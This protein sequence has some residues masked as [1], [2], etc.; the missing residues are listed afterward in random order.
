MSAVLSL[1][2]RCSL[3][4]PRCGYYIEFHIICLLSLG[5]S[6]LHAISGQQRHSGQRIHQRPSPDGAG[7]RSGPIPCLWD[8][9]STSLRHRPSVVHVSTA[10]YLA[11]LLFF[12]LCTGHMLLALI[13]WSIALRWVIWPILRQPP[14]L[15]R[16]FYLVPKKKKKARSPGDGARWHRLLNEWPA[17]AWIIDHSTLAG[18]YSQY[19]EGKAFTPLRAFMLEPAVLGVYSCVC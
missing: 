3:V 5:S 8:S 9:L 10:T 16:I 2:F 11:F 6:S 4:F 1:L 12:I 15:S 18:W 17:K 19:L 13:F 7:E 14:L